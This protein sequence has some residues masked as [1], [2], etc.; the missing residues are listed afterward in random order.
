MACR[1][2]HEPCRILVAESDNSNKMHTPKAHRVEI[3]PNG[4]IS[5]P[6]PRIFIL[7]TPSVCKK[8]MKIPCGIA[9]VNRKELCMN[10][11]YS[12]SP[13]RHLDFPLL[14]SSPGAFAPEILI[15]GE[16]PASQQENLIN[17]TASYAQAR[18]ISF[19]YQI[20]CE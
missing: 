16:I 19:I 6:L 12:Q 8:R 7:C 4:H 14:R 18:R 11:Y 13:S 15:L 5:R 1:F 20:D 3:C 2:V 17:K 10:S 9:A